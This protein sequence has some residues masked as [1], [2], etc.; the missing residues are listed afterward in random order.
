MPALLPPPMPLFSCST[1]RTS[2]YR[3]RTKAT[4]SSVEPLSTTTISRPRTESR[5]CSIQGSAFHVT[6][7]TETSGWLIHH[8]RPPPDALPQDDRQ[9][10]KREHDRHD[11]E[12]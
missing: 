8:S 6:T 11:E 4:V 10:R 5:H 7:T 3:S 12:D 9:A 2:G 1:T